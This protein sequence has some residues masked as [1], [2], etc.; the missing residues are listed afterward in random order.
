MM[1]MQTNVD[2]GV[3]APPPAP[4]ADGG[5]LLPY[6]G[7]PTPTPVPLLDGGATPKAPR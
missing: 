7:G 2:A 3:G 6:D 1:P 4:G 5:V